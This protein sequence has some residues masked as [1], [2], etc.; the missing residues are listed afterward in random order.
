MTAVLALAAAGNSLKAGEPTINAAGTWRVTL[1]STNTAVQSSAQT[2]KL[3]VEG[4]ALTGTL[5]YYSSPMIN[6]KA[7]VSELPITDGKLEGDKISFHFTHPPASGNGPNA[8][9]S[10][11]GA[12]SANSIK[13]T[14]TTEWMGH[15]HTR[16][17]EATRAK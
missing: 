5:T 6:G 15:T 8:N 16:N 9:Y 13:G 12:I 2:L 7:R 1:T 11:Q 4:G 10:Y 3:K 17:W 14:V